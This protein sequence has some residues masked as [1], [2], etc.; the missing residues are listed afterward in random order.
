MSLVEKNKLKEFTKARN[1]FEEFIL[2]HKNF[3]NQIVVK[4]GSGAKGFAWIKA[5]YSIVL[6]AVQSGKKE[7]EIIEVLKKDQFEF[8]AINE[9]D[10]ESEGA[11]GKKFSRATKAQAYITEAIDKALRCSICGARMNPKSVQIEHVER[12][13]D[14]GTSGMSNAK[15][16][17]PYCNS[18]FK[19]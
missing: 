14:G 11:P 7:N 6:A 2:K 19:G 8:L 4:R 17:H 15:L 13:E 16:A 10:A 18:T 3:I 5:F 9:T 1:E 12:R